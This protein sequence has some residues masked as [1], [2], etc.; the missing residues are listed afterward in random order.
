ML[1]YLSLLTARDVFEEIHLGF[2]MV[3]HTHED[4]DAMFGHFSE[5]LMHHPSYSL[6]DLM[7][8]LMRARTPN[9]V[10]HFVQEVPDFKSYLEPYLLKGGDALIGHLQ[11]R[12]FR[13]YVRG[14]GM[15]CLQYKLK[16][17]DDDW[18]PRE[19]IEMWSWTNNHP[20][21][22]TGE[23]KRLPMIEMSMLEEVRQGLQKQVKFFDFVGTRTTSE[24]GKNRWAALVQYWNRIIHTL[25]TE[26][27][28]YRSGDDNLVHGF[29]PVSKWRDNVPLQYRN[30]AC[31]LDA[32][33]AYVG[34]RKNKPREAFNPRVD[35]V[36]GNYVLVRPDTNDLEVYPIYLGKVISEVEE[37]EVNDNDQLEHVCSVEWY[38]P[39][40]QRK[41]GQP[42]CEPRQRWLDC[43]NQQWERDPGYCS[44]VICV[45][46]V[47]WSFKARTTAK[48]GLV[49]I[50]K[51]HAMKAK[52][53][54][55]RCLE[56]EAISTSVALNT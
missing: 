12:L 25:E 52:D 51:S 5:T 48:S 29:W 9:P 14:D 42:E 38:R 7:S 18:V 26:V 19:G 53:N 47:L 33:V 6:A 2:L 45:N 10:P 39:Y 55:S 31:E 4:V 40:I 37:G 17:Q 41:R 13:L 28:Q 27:V 3:G 15:P 30:V 21:L 49:R 43:W 50:A 35:I 22:P 23:P 24:E 11:P 54:M 32:K 20:K 8:L 46:T 36:K 44:E 16:C 56:N 34:P 1:G